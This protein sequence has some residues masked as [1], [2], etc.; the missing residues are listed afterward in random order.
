[1]RIA[2]LTAVLLA[3]APAFAQA[4]SVGGFPNP[5]PSN[6]LTFGTATGT[7]GDGGVLASTQATANAAIPSA[8]KGAASGVAALNANSQTPTGY[9]VNRPTITPL[10]TTVGTSPTTI[11]SAGVFAAIRIAI[12]TPGASMAC[13]GDGTT[14]ALGGSG[15]AYYPQDIHWPVV[16][17]GAMPAGAVQCIA[18][19]SAAV[20]AEA[21]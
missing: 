21:H 10:T 14:P 1:M 9:L 16:T 12:N 15:T 11:Y 7:V 20:L 2:M 18:S 13:T 5:V 3:A 19:I 4:P 8:Q 6:M 17:F